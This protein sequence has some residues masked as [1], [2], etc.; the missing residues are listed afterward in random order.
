MTETHCHMSSVSTCVHVCNGQWAVGGDHAGLLAS[1]DQTAGS[2]TVKHAPDQQPRPSLCQNKHCRI[3]YKAPKA[4]LPSCQV[5]HK[6]VY[7]AATAV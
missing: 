7:H 5:V 3:L 6:A 1:S 2:A 4:M